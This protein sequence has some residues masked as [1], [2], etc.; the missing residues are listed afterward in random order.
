MLSCRVS[1]GAGSSAAATGPAEHCRKQ[2]ARAHQKRTA[3]PGGG[4]TCRA[5]PSVQ[6]AG[7]STARWCCS[8]RRLEMPTEPS[9]LACWPV[10][11][12]CSSACTCCSPACSA[13]C[14]ACP[15]WGSGLAVA[16]ARGKAV[17]PPVVGDLHQLRRHTRVSDAGGSLRNH[18]DMMSM[19]GEASSDAA[20]PPLRLFAHLR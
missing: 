6:C 19:V 7:T 9:L 13:P 4:A 15:C 12:A 3:E 8:R 20:V 11:P 18:S 5:A 14:A 10:S 16:F 17:A 1:R 2:A